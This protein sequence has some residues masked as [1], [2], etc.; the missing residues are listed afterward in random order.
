[1]LSIIK[2]KWQI[3]IIPVILLLMII[4]VTIFLFQNRNNPNN[5]L[6]GT[7]RFINEKPISEVTEEEF[8][9]AVS[10]KTDFFIIYNQSVD[11][12]D[13]L[14][15]YAPFFTRDEIRPYL[16]EYLLELEIEEASIYWND[17]IVPEIENIEPANT[18]D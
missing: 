9:Q 5:E 7:N 17:N 13:F 16:K 14:I 8:K 15:E 1:M 12:S 3:F 11:G 10:Y 4:L 18:F 2:E 6:I